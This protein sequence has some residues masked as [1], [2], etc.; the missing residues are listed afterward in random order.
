MKNYK[1]AEPFLAGAEGGLWAI[2]GGNYLLAKKL[3]EASGANH[4][5][6]NVS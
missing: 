5:K 3:F 1:W 6:E 2:E 4:M